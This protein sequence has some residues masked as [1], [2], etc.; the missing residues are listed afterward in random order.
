MSPFEDRLSGTFQVS[1]HDLLRIYMILIT[2]LDA[3]PDVS[4]RSILSTLLPSPMS[5]IDLEN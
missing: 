2:E 4:S 5:I 1:P 3:S